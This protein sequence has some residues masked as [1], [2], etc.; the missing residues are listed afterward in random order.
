MFVTLTTNTTIGRSTPRPVFVVDSEKHTSDLVSSDGFKISRFLSKAGYESLAVVA[1][2]ENDCK[3]EFTDIDVECF[4]L[5]AAPRIS[6][7]ELTELYTLLHKVI[8]ETN[9]NTLVISGS[10]NP[11]LGP[12]YFE[13]LRRVA[14]SERIELVADITDDMAQAAIKRGGLALV[15][16]SQGQLEAI[17][18][19][20]F[21]TLGTLIE[22]AWDMLRYENKRVLVTLGVKG[23]ILV[24]VDSAWF[25]HASN[26]KIWAAE[27][28]ESAALS[29]YLTQKNKEPEIA[30]K[31]AI[32]WGI[33]ASKSS[34]IADF[35]PSNIDDVAVKITRQPNMD[36]LLTQL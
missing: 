12:L 26:D 8:D 29:G 9:A 4:K 28:A 27:N 2:S 22:A 35:D 24:D 15:K 14:F 3:S 5:K 23:S 13:K 31:T 18:G 30:L 6:E 34:N 7:S 16:L 25:A 19:T 20:T 21:K 33:V 32:A 36:K 1:T 10:T 17:S 11:G